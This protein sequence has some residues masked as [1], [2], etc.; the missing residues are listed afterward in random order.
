MIEVKEYYDDS[1]SRMDYD[2]E[3]QYDDEMRYVISG[4]YD[5]RFRDL[6]SN[7]YCDDY[8]EMLDCVWDYMNQGLL[9]SVYDRVSGKTVK[10]ESGTMDDITWGGYDP[11]EYLSDE[12][13]KLDSSSGYYENYMNESKDNKHL[14]ELYDK[15][16][17]RLKRNPKTKTLEQIMKECKD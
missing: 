2:E 11:Y 1:I 15:G 17:E 6:C 12:L 5:V 16:I 3:N 10:F 7:H 13:K 14:N 4:Y 9:V 8:S